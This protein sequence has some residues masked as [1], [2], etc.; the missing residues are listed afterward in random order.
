M[1]YF[2]AFK[3]V[4]V[5]NP[6]VPAHLC[7]NELSILRQLLQSS[8]TDDIL[9]DEFG[10]LRFRGQICGCVLDAGP[11]RGLQ[12][13]LWPKVADAYLRAH[14]GRKVIFYRGCTVSIT[15]RGILLRFWNPK[16]EQIL[17]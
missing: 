2:T 14:L 4:A 16:L 10:R 12:I 15:R 17:A 6:P 1:D 13:K 5:W 11:Q 7:Q 3:N 8:N 9:L